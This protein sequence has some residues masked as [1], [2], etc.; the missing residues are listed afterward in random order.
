[1]LLFLKEKYYGQVRDG[2]VLCCHRSC[3]HVMPYVKRTY[4]F[5]SQP[6]SLPI[7]NIWGFDWIVCVHKICDLSSAVLISA[8]TWPRHEA[9]R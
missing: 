8:L 4:P 7:K 3:P 2:F 6:L 1:M 5:H 9:S